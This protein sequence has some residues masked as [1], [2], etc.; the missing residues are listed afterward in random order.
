MRKRRRDGARNAGGDGGNAGSDGGGNRER[1]EQRR[2]ERWEVHAATGAGS[3]CRSRRNRH[4]DDQR[5]EKQDA[6]LLHGSILP[7][8][9][10]YIPNVSR[11]A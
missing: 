11:T 1:K 5:Y 7:L 9:G 6:E 3:M 4:E 2:Q 8:K 10:M